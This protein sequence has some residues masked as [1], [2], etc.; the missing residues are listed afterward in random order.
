M[1]VRNNSLF[2]LL[3]DLMNFSFRRLI[4][5]DSKISCICCCLAES[6]ICYVL[7]TDLCMGI[8]KV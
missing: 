4:L 8:V 2:T 1:K 3:N 7:I 5:N 6:L